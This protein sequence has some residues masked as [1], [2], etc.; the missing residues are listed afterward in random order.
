MDERRFQL[1]I[2]NDIN[3]LYWVHYFCVRNLEGL[4]STI[5]IELISYI[6]FGMALLL[7][8]H[9]QEHYSAAVGFG[10][11]DLEWTCTSGIIGPGSTPTIL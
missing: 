10:N 1:S 11:A 4:D 5:A 2:R 6:N 8:R 9:C 3:R 7:Q